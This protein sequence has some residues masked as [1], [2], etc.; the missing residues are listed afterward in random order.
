MTPEQRKK[1][2]EAVKARQKELREKGICLRCARLKAN[3]GEGATKVYCAGC[4][5]KVRDYARTRYRLKKGLNVDAPVTATG[6]P[7]IKPPKKNKTKN[8]NQK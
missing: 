4:S 5:K 1:K 3:R 8:Q 2:T 7:R 6:R